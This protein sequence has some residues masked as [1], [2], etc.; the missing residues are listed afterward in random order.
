[1]SFTT[2]LT[3]LTALAVLLGLKGLWFLWHLWDM[4]RDEPADYTGEE[5]GRRQ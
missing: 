4:S 1:M 2:G 5:F 3:I